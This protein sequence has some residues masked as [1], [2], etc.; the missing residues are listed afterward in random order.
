MST[1]NTHYPTS[2]FLF[3][4]VGSIR[5]EDQKISK[6]IFSFPD[7]PQFS[8]REKI[9]TPSDFVQLEVSRRIGVYLTS[10][11]S[12]NFNLSIDRVLRYSDCSS[13]LLLFRFSVDYFCPDSFSNKVIFGIST[14]KV[15]RESSVKQS[16]SKTIWRS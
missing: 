4:V 9:I 5:L 2:R 7:F 3:R 10:L 1:H 15:F 13:C 16:H 12:Q 14:V 6:L 8:Y 11:F